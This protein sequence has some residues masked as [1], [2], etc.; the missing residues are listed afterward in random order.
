M[1]TLRTYSHWVIEP[2]PGTSSAQMTSIMRGVSVPFIT[3]TINCEWSFND[4]HWNWACGR[5][6]WWKEHLVRHINTYTILVPVFFFLSHFY[7]SVY[8]WEQKE[9]SCSTAIELINYHPCLAWRKKR[10]RPRTERGKSQETN[11]L[12][13]TS[14][15]K[16]N[17]SN[18]WC[19]SSAWITENDS[20]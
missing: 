10:E 14:S 17:T 16:L 7:L 3:A 2:L 11:Y 12:T 6:S 9:S 18:K 13:K 8:V 20:K 15:W 4:C 19:A 5:G 1:A